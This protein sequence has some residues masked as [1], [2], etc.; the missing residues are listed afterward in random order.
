MI[1]NLHPR[2]TRESQERKHQPTVCS[3]LSTEFATDQE[4]GGQRL[5]LPEALETELAEL[6]LGHSRG[7]AATGVDVSATPITPALQ[8]AA[9]GE[10]PGVQA[11]H[12]LQSETL[13]PN[14]R[15]AGV[16]AQLVGCFL[17]SPKHLGLI[18]QHRINW[19]WCQALLNLLSGSG[20]SGVQGHP[21]ICRE[22]EANLECMRLS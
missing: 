16:V 14:T 21:Q 20:K 5:V 4:I 10:L 8:E 9:A 7:T 15:R 22:F 18:S 11:Q 12:G 6:T 3:C 2:C 17:S 1:V 13:S 19:D